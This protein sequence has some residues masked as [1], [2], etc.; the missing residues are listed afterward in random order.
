MTAI[1]TPGPVL[2]KVPVAP[3]E[4]NVTVATSAGRTPALKTGTPPK[5]AV[6]VPSY[7]LLLAVSPVMVNTMAVMLAVSAGWLTV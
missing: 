7:T 1:A 3:P 4:F 6:V 5:V 2:A